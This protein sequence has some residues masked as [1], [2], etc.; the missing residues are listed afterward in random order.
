M[1]T[2]ISRRARSR[3]LREGP[4]RT[5]RRPDTDPITRLEAECQETR[6]EAID[7]AAELL[8]R[9]AD[10][11][12]DRDQCFGFRPRAIVRSSI[13]PIVASMSGVLVSPT[14]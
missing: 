10:V 12:F 3:E 11:L 6:S 13:S 5:I 8:V 9:P 4:F 2:W 14:T 1:L 7:A